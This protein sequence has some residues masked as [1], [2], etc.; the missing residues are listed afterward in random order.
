MRLAW[1]LLFSL[2]IAPCWAQERFNSGWLR[3]FTNVPYVQEDI[4]APDVH[5]RSVRGTIT[6]AVGDKSGLPDTLVE[7]IGPGGSDRLLSATTD[8]NGR[9]SIPRV[10]QGT[11]RFRVA[12]RGFQRLQRQASSL[13]DGTV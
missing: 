10:P 1:A 4:S 13:Q 2:T 6:R 9:F 3:G 11:Y 7:I 5:V 8:A 12:C